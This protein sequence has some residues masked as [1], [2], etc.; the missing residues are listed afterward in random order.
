MTLEQL[1]SL[2]WVDVLF[3]ALFEPRSLYRYIKDNRSFSIYPTFL[4]PA[5]VTISE[6]VTLY[7]LKAS[8]QLLSYSLTYG[9]ILNFM[10]ISVIIIIS[11]S[12]IDTARQFAGFNGNIKHI[13]SV[14]NISM[15]PKIF[16][17]PVTYIFSVI[18][19]G[20]IF[21]YFLTSFGLF[22]WSSLIIVLGVSEMN[23]ASFG[24]SLL[25]CIFPG[26]LFFMTIFFTFLLMLIG[27]FQ[28]FFT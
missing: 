23:G 18:D 5:M 14:M 10:F 24:K 19:F 27:F 4:V 9:W 2:K 8:N 3:Y 11:A 15:F 12:L 1:K 17:L 25:V 6:I 20:S 26:M 16:L 22:V 28:F 21:F 7:L 13:I